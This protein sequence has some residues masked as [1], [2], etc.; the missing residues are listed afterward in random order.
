MARAS[1]GEIFRC[2]ITVYKVL[3]PKNVEITRER[4]TRT[5]S[6]DNGGTSG[7]AHDAVHE[8]AATR[9]KC[10]VNEIACGRKIVDY[11]VV[12]SVLNR[13]YKV[14]LVATRQVRAYRNKVCDRRMLVDGFCTRKA[15]KNFS[16]VSRGLRDRSAPRYIQLSLENGV[17]A[18]YSYTSRLRGVT[19]GRH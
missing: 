11:V 19:K 14:V 4:C 8:H 15:K 18:W 17:N 1:L 3:K 10:T 13:D 5:V 7:D 9:C 16:R 2:F 6:G 12:F